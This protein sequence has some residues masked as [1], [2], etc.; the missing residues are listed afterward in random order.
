[1]PDHYKTSV[2]ARLE[3]SI[4]GTSN[5]IEHAADTA[6]ASMRRLFCETKWR[7]EQLGFVFGSN[8]EYLITYPAV[9]K[10]DEC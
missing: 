3:M 8:V 4:E 6:I 1:M 2:S 10:N 5:D 7:A 9:K